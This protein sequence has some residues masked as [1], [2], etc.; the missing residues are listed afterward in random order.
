MGSVMIVQLVG[1]VQHP[2]SNTCSLSA[3]PPMQASVEI[4]PHNI[5]SETNPPH[6][7]FME[8]AKKTAFLSMQKMEGSAIYT[9]F[10]VRVLLLGTGLKNCASRKRK[11][12]KLWL[13]K[14]QI[15]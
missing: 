12:A 10:L 6:H 1:G 7:C 3:A 13:K 4:L 11:L 2:K 8:N 15:E 9:M 14:W 5:K